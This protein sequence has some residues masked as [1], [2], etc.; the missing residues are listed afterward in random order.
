[1]ALLEIRIQRATLFYQFRNVY[2]GQYAQIP[3]VPMPPP[4]QTYGVRWEWFN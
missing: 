1:M 4:F 3:G 2:G